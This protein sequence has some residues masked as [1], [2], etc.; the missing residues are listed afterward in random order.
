MQFEFEINKCI[1]EQNNLDNGKDDITNFPD[2]FLF[3][4]NGTE[5]DNNKLAKSTI[6][7]NEDNDLDEPI[8]IRM[9]YQSVLRVNY[10]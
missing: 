10:Q 2:E 3:D 1:F 8:S 6:D 9:L 5:D 4:G 7:S